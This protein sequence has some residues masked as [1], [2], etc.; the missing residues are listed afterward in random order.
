MAPGTSWSGWLFKPSAQSSRLRIAR[1]SRARYSSARRQCSSGICRRANTHARL[2]REPP[3]R[4]RL[5]SAS[6]ASAGRLIARS[7]ACS[8]LIDRRLLRPGSANFSRS[9]ETRQDN[10]LVA[11]RGASVARLSR[12]GISAR[13]MAQPDERGGNRH[14]QP[15]VTAPHFDS[16]DSN[17]PVSSATPLWAARSSEAGPYRNPKKANS[18]PAKR[19]WLTP[20]IAA[21]GDIGGVVRIPGQPSACRPFVPPSKTT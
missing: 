5:L 17:R 6:A 9:G 7:G 19:H 18:R 3:D 10:D 20:L 14:A 11:L 16:T 15:N 13:G 21:G 1:A 2:A 12:R 8:L 4:G